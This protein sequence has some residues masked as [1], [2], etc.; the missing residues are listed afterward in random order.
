MTK[1]RLLLLVEGVAFALAGLIHRGLLIQGYAHPMAS[2]AESTIAVVL[3]AGLALT[4]LWPPRTRPI[5]VAA[6]ALAFL[7][8]L[9]GAFTIAIG[10]GPRSALDIAFHAAILLTLLC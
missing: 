6:Q 5:A 3:F 1:L 9:V 4:L 7:G 8:T 10:I 2:I